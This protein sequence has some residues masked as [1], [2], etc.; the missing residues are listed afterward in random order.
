MGVMTIFSLPK[1]VR[2]LVDKSFEHWLSRRI[3]TRKEHQLN[4]RNIMIYPTRFGLSYLGFVVLVFLLG[5]NYQ[6]NI[7]LLFSY[8]LASLFISVMLHSFYNFSQL[9]FYSTAKQQGYAGDELYFPIQITAVK[10]HYDINVHFTDSTLNSQIERIVQCPQG[11]QEIKLSY[12]SSKR[13]MHCLGRVTLFSEYSLGIFK[14][15]TILDFGHC[16]IIY[17]KPTNL[18]AGQYQ[19]SAQS[20]EQSIESYQTS[21]LVGT[22]DFSELKSFVRG[23]SRARTAWK[24]LAKGQGHYS[25]HYQANQG[26]LKWLKL[27][28]MPSNNIETKLSYLCFLIN[29]LTATNQHFGLALSTDINNKSMNISPNTGI[30]HQQAC[31]TALALYS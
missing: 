21:N 27:D 30:N 23:E 28:D 2:K 8:L 16:A 13:G 7:I 22:D 6:N 24:Q 15:K 19:L 17:P 11:S 10:M 18:I 26:Q 31:L 4:S 20:D 12:K 1:S 29:E 5:T 25:K 9:R 14:S 3:P